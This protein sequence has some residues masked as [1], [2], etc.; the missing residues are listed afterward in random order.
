MPRREL[1][2][3]AQRLELL[4]LPEDE[5]EFIRLFTLSTQDLAVVRQR[6]GAANRLGFAVQL[7][8][9]RYPGQ[10][11]GPDDTPNQHVL[12]VIAKQLRIDQGLWEKYAESV[13]AVSK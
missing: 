7:C 11:L 12:S 13:I 10:V 5:A 3:P 6:R 9:I 2:S 1:F 4:A 8:S